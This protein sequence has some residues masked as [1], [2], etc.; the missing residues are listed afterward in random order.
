MMK[1]KNWHWTLAL[2]LLAGLAL[3]TS[4]CRRGGVSLIPERSEVWQRPK[5]KGDREVSKDAG[6]GQGDRVWTQSQGRA[7][8]KWPDLWVRLYDDTDLHMDVL[9]PTGVTLA[10]DVGTILSGGVSKA[11]E[12]AVKTDS[13]AE[14][15]SVGTTFMVAYHPDTG[16]TLVRVFDGQAQVRN[17]TGD[18]QTEVVIRVGEWA[19]VRPATIPEV[20]Y[21]LE[22]MRAL[23]R[24]LGLWDVFHE[25]ELDVEAGF[26]PS[27]SRVPPEDVDIV[28]VEEA[29]P[30]PT[31]TRVPT[32]TRTPVPS[33]TWTRVP[34]STRTP[35]PSPTWTP[36]PSAPEMRFWADRDCVLAEQEECT[37][38]RW[39]V[40]YAEAVYL[41]GNGVA[42]YDSRQVCPG[43]TT[44]Y[45]LRA[46]GPGGQ[47]GQ[48]LTITV[49]QV[50]FWADQ[51]SIAAGG[52]STLHWDVE[53][54]QA[55]YM[56]RNGVVGHG[57]QSVCP[58]T[59]RAF[60]LRVVSACGE[61]EY[62]VEI[63]VVQPQALPAPLQISPPNGSVFDHVP[64]TTTLEW[65]DVP[66]DPYTDITYCVEIDCY[67]CCGWNTWCTDVGVTFYEVVCGLHK[68]WYTFDFVGAQPGRWRVWA[69]ESGQEGAKSGWWEFRY[70]Q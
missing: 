36:R 34:T 17:L 16:F 59:T 70:T 35:V 50:S 27:G 32:S 52:C 62:P 55:V 5:G 60:V 3:S 46:V 64:R 29:T 30:T 56:D 65:E 11:G 31:R 12:Y 67:H 20:R 19:L 14:I 13:C 37:V 28:F 33:P 1:R 57:S 41:D 26:G 43:Q 58:E 9:T 38:L 66:H 7:L 15:K 10:M 40:D 24:K 69:V 49:P 48:S 45:A 54:A 21:R 61:L 39:E 44:T 47:V 4:Q 25:V 42:S 53:G 8:L 68:T 63:K 2:L 22:D 51:Y 6:V 23:A 18:V